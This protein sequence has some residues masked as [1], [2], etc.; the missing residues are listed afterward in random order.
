[1]SNGVAVKD[2]T[3]LNRLPYLKNQEKRRTGM[4]AT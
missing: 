2:L 1:M 3:K 4:R